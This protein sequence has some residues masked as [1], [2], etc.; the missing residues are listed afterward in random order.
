MKNDENNGELVVMD[1]HGGG[2]RV[3]RPL[4]VHGRLGVE[5]NGDGHLRNDFHTEIRIPSSSVLISSIVVVVVV[6]EYQGTRN[7]RVI[8]DTDLPSTPR[9]SHYNSN[10]KVHHAHACMLCGRANS[11]HVWKYFIESMRR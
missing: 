10:D 9:L 5:Q 2:W 7:T 3:Y 8:V 1:L 11:S 4:L 6:A